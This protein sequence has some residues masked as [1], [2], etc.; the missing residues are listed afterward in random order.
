[1]IRRTI[2]FTVVVDGEDGKEDNDKF[3]QLIYITGRWLY[4]T[5]D[6]MRDDLELI[7]EDK[8]VFNPDEKRSAEELF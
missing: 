4:E 1:M 2:T 3:H 6:W 5:I 8:Q 7:I